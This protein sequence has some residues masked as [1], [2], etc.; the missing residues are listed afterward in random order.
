MYTYLS[1][2]VQSYIYI[3]IYLSN[4]CTHTD[5][6]WGESAEHTA[7]QAHT[8]LVGGNRWSNIKPTKDNLSH[9]LFPQEFMEAWVVIF[10]KYNTTLP[11]SASVERLFSFGSDI[12]RPKRSSLT[13]HN[14]E[15]LVMMKGNIDIKKNHNYR[16]RRRRRRMKKRWG[17]RL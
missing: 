11:S 1:M 4:L 15:Q 7:V 12:L 14:F 6:M 5:H 8:A 3:Y 9:H 10:L 2:S 17:D 16:K 13:S